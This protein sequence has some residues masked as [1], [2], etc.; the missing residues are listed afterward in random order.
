MAEGKTSSAYI[1]CYA[2]APT[3]LLP[4][5]PFLGCDISVPLSSSLKVKTFSDIVGRRT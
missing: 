2:I 3:S 4:A 1:I 5:L